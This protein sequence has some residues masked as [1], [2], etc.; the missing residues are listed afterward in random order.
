MN[1]SDRPWSVTHISLPFPT[2]V[3]CSPISLRIF[4]S[5]SSPSNPSNPRRVCPGCLQTK[6]YFGK[7]VPI[8]PRGAVCVLLFL[9]LDIDR[10]SSN[11]NEGSSAQ[12]AQ[13]AKP[14]NALCECPGPSL[15]PA[16]SAVLR[17]IYAASR[18]QGCVAMLM[19]CGA[20]KRPIRSIFNLELMP[21]L[22]SISSKFGCSPR[23]DNVIARAPRWLAST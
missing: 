11:Q 5:H 7:K 2:R 8:R 21:L 22:L 19:G 13:H 15:Y 20:P 10:G 23:T 9:D 17:L 18:L 14:V 3:V 6:L 16:P 12:H 4:V 1:R